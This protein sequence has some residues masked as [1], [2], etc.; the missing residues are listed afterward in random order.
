MAYHLALDMAENHKIVFDNYLWIMF[1]LITAGER[2]YRH[3]DYRASGIIDQM[4]N[5]F[6]ENAINTA[7]KIGGR[8]EDNMHPIPE[9]NIESVIANYPSYLRIYWKDLEKI[10]K[11]D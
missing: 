8:R 9:K 3:L 7:M 5:G 1:F 2:K 4:F 10:R 11:L 6:Y